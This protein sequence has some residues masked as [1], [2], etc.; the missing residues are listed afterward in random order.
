MK[1]QRGA[2]LLVIL[3]IVGVLG[4][5][6]AVRAL[7]GLTAER[8]RVT[9]AALAQAKDALIGYAVTYRDTHPDAVTSELNKPFGYLPCPDTNNDGIAELTCGLKDV[10]V[11][12]RLPW[13]TLGLAP[14]RDSAGECLWYAV[15]G[16]AKNSANTDVLN[17][18][19]LG[20]FPISEA[21]TGTTLAAADTH[22]TPW[23]VVFAPRAVIAAQTRA[24]AAGSECGGNNNVASY[25][26][27][28][29][30]IYAGVAPSANANTTL[31][32][33]SSES[34]R[35]GSNNDQGLWITGKEIFDRVKKRSDFKKDIGDM[36]GDLAACL[37][38]MPPASLPAAAGSKGIDG[39]L[40]ACLEPNALKN[41]VRNNWKDNLLYAK[42]PTST[43]ITIDGNNSPSD[44][45][46]VLI[47]SG[48]RTGVQT[49]LTATDKTNAG[50]YLEAP[51]ATSF[52]NGTS[53]S[54]AAT[55][56][57]VNQSQDIVACISAT[58]PATPGTQISFASDFATFAAAGSGVAPDSA[59]QTVTMATASGNNGG[60]FWS[61]SS[62]PLAG[63]TIRAY[64]EFKFTT[65]DNHPPGL[66]LGNGFTLQ[67]VTAD[68]GSAPNT[69]GTETAMGAL[70][71]TDAWGSN[72]IIVET[73]VHQDT[74][75]ISDPA[76]NHTAIMLNGNIGHTGSGDTMSTACNG[77]AAG[78]R[79]AP[80]NKF[81]ESPVTVQHN[82]RIE[83]HTGCTPGCGSCDPA[84][85]SPPN[86]YARIT[87]WVDCIDCKDVVTNLN[88]A[89]KVPSVQRCVTL[90]APMYPSGSMNNVFF[91]FT[92][93][94]RSGASQQGVTLK[95]LV[96]RSE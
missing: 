91:G 87:A 52:P 94:F 2:A 41:N 14:L 42:L 63:K 25:L 39:P 1:H 58:A 45:A 10:S 74:G 50:N 64:Y 36:M 76:E 73:D 95:N 88:R 67:L 4:A 19:T 78:C 54:G 20:Q 44:C 34:V 80:A 7:N 90:G 70:G 93:G 31:T 26:D 51:N 43:S 18:D 15:S 12:G 9:A 33:S 61:P 32:L 59:T 24:G 77:T 85:H 75:L 89:V 27:G 35:V 96:L 81:E 86:I 8:D 11:T 17:W 82:Q 92:G 57:H 72:S 37:N 48:E 47:F 3:M 5:F 49:R 71:A 38:T 13:K 21:I 46:A 65:A 53:Y 28:A 23:A 69:C 56:N 55:Y 60:C 22:T 16:R 29:D 79:H 68:F 66:D 40:A 30:P 62:L 84:S 83:I 6:F